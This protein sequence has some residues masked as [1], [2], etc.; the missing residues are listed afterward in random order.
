MAAVLIASLALT[1]YRCEDWRDAERLF[2]RMATASPSS[3]KAANGLGHVYED[4]GQLA[5]AAVEYGRAA[6][7]NPAALQ[8]VLSLALVESRIGLHEQAARRAEAIRRLDPD[9]EAA[10][11]LAW[12][13]SSAGQHDEAAA[14]LAVAAARQARIAVAGA[15]P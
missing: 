6:A 4:R 14:A 10:L 1:A 11:Q 9:G 7:L 2:T 13:H 8:P 3:W 12:I 15:T 5:A